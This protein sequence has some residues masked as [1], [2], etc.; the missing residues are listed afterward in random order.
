MASR[1][2]T[3]GPRR[4]LIWA[5]MAPAMTAMAN[6]GVASQWT[7]S[8]DLLQTFRTQAGITAGPVGLTVMRMRFAVTSQDVPSDIF[9]QLVIGVRV[10]DTQEAVQ[11]EADATAFS[12]VT[13]PHADWMC[14][15]PIGF[16]ANSTRT[17]TPPLK[18]VDHH[19]DVRSMRKF[20]ELG[21]TLVLVAGTT[22]PYGGA[23]GATFPLFITSSVLLALP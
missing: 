5:R 22:Q 3:R 7:E 16:P 18:I 20:E 21:Q 1:R 2:P 8:Q 12:P 14:Y 15:E 6:V 23:A 19:I 10:M 13:D 17:A 9:G 4:K 11:A